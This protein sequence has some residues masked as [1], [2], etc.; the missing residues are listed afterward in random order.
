MSCFFVQPQGHSVLFSCTV[1]RAFFHHP[2]PIILCQLTSKET[3]IHLPFQR[4]GSL[5]AVLSGTLA[6]TPGCSLK[7]TT[8]TQQENDCLAGFD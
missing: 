6:R 2:L 1:A 8:G 4:L 5:A 3:H 7:A